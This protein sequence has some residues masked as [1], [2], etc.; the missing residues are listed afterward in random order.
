[1]YSLAIFDLRL[2]V[3]IQDWRKKTASTLTSRLIV[4][5]GSHRVPKQL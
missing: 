4:Y 3:D 2:E 1:M 5:L